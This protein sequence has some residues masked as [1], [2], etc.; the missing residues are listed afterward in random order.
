MMMKEKSDRINESEKFLAKLRT[1]KSYE[2]PKDPIE[3]RLNR[4]ERD[5]LLYDPVL[6]KNE[7]SPS[8][9]NQR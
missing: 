5:M 3:K 7:K 6:Q 4:W 2:R 9:D 1:H 8:Q